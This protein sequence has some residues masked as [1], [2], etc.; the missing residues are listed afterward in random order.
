MGE[1]DQ[2]SMN[3]IAVDPEICG[4]KPFLRGT[5]ISVAVV[6]DAL[7][8]GLS[9]EKIIEHYPVLEKEDVEAALIFA[10][11]LAEENGGIAVVGRAF[12]D[13]FLLQR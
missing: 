4:G 8:Q 5:R 13:D 3:R 12:P 11:R 1:A 6:L 10:M 2:R 7:A 9:A